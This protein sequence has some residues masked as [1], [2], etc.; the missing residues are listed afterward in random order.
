M[1]HHYTQLYNIPP[2]CL[3]I[4]GLQ[5]ISKHACSGFYSQ[6]V[7]HVLLESCYVF[8]MTYSLNRNAW[9]VPSLMVGRSQLRC[10]NPQSRVGFLQFSESPLKMLSCATRV[11]IETDII[12]VECQCRESNVNRV[13]SERVASSQFS[14]KSLIFVSQ[15]R[16]KSLSTEVG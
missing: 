16:A 9:L 5:G 1:I 6:F 4:L 13:R 14:G 15:C 11:L 7:L 2:L 12:L 3:Q 10:L 8:G